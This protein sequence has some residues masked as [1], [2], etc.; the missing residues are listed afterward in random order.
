[1]VIKSNTW[2]SIWLLS[3]NICNL[4]TFIE[5]YIQSICQFHFI[6]VLFEL[7][8]SDSLSRIIILQI[9]AYGLR[10]Q[11]SRYCSPLLTVYLCHVSLFIEFEF[12]AVLQYYVICLVCYAR[13][14]SYKC[15]VLMLEM[16][17]Q[18]CLCLSR[19]FAH[20]NWFSVVRICLYQ[21]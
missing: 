7:N 15:N 5:G 18:H 17:I 12:C 6:F 1:M 13:L 9:L 21:A 8:L 20:I 3:I 10:N 2:H 19:E 4:E 16:L 11:F 14:D